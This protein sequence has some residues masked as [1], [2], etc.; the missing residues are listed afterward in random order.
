MNMLSFLVGLTEVI[1][2]LTGLDPSMPKSRTIVFPLL[3]ISKL[4]LDIWKKLQKLE[5]IP[6]T[7]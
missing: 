5:L 3:V 1:I 2:K 4:T 7:L 6:Q